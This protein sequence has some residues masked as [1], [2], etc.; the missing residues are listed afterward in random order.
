MLLGIVCFCSCFYVCLGAAL[1]LLIL[2]VSKSLIAGLG[3]A[4]DGE[5]E[6]NASPRDGGRMRFLGF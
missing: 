3:D 2:F 4:Y 1:P 5:K 6:K